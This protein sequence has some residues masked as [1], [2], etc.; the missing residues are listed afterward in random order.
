MNCPIICTL[1]LMAF[2][3]PEATNISGEFPTVAFIVG[4]NAGP[5]L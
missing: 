3:I 1:T 4:Q 5:D 2:L